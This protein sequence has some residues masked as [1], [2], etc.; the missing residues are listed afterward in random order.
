MLYRHRNRVLPMLIATA[1]VVAATPTVVAGA[2]IPECFGQ[3]ATI[4]GTA[5][6]DV[7]VGTAG[8][9]VIVGSAGIDKISGGRGDDRIC[10]GDNPFDPGDEFDDVPP[11]YETLLGE[12]GNDFIAGEDGTDLLDGGPG[13]DELRPGPNPDI[14]GEDDSFYA[15]FADGGSGDDLIYGGPDM[16]DLYGGSGDDRLSGGAGADELD[17]ES[18]NDILHGG[19]GF[20]RLFGGRGSDVAYAGPEGDYWNGSGG[21]DGDVDRFYGGPG[22]DGS[23]G[24]DH[25]RQII[26][27]GAGADFLSG[28]NK[29]DII[30]GGSGDDTLTG[31]RGDDDLRGGAGKDTVDY[32]TVTSDDGGSETENNN[33]MWVDLQR[34]V[35]TGL[36]RDRLSSVEAIVGGINDDVLLGSRGR[37]SFYLEDYISSSRGHDVIDGRGGR[38]SIEPSPTGV[39]EAMRVDLAAGTARV[40]DGG[41]RA[42]LK[43]IETAIG[44]Y[45]DDVL[46]GDGHSNTLRGMEGDDVISGRG[47]SDRIFGGRGKDD[48]NGGGG[49]DGLNGDSGADRLDGGPGAD[50]NNGGSGKDQCAQSRTRSCCP[51]LRGVDQSGLA[52]LTG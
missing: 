52:I 46:S 43:S 36:G 20:N 11:V 2:T 25:G 5:G 23:D 39:V 24:G 34:G 30:I 19:E 33:K 51:L 28:G 18:G 22:D 15:G 10:G 4:I 17:G 49:K 9:D 6:D 40:E 8:P 50:R 29:E 27:G 12:A 13:D 26:R 1:L 35:A 32:S 37:N 48:L 16:D 14:E 41:G 21:V 3:P 45:G 7:L 42:E 47:G 31:H 38:D 44:S